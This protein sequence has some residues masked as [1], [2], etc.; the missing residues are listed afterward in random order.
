MRAYSSLS[1]EK[2]SVTYKTNKYSVPPELVGRKLT[3]K[4]DTPLQKGGLFHAED[5]IRQFHFLPAGTHQKDIRNEDREA[6]FA[7]WEKQRK[8]AT[9]KKPQKR[10]EEQT[11]VDIRNPAYY[12]RFLSV[13]VSI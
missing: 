9:R 12:E 7:L 10:L 11:V 1:A 13:G 3:L 6:L 5:S 4:I 2:L 8:N